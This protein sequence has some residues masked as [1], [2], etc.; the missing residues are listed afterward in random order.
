VTTQNNYTQIINNFNNSIASSNKPQQINQ[1][2]Q[3]KSHE[4]L[5]PNATAAQKDGDM[6]K[7]KVVYGQHGAPRVQPLGQQP[8][9]VTQKLSL[10]KLGSHGSFN[11]NRAN[12]SGGAGGSAYMINQ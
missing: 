12:S 11:S 2:N 1:K 5:N 9:P 4:H 6:A 8:I 3:A 7:T 10:Q